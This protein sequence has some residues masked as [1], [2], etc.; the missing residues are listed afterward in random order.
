MGL[1]LLPPL[2]Q[3]SAFLQLLLEEL[4]GLL[5]GIRIV[6][7]TGIEHSGLRQQRQKLALITQSGKMNVLL[8]FILQM[9][10]LGEQ[11]HMLVSVLAPG[12]FLLERNRAD[13]GAGRE[14]IAGMEN[15]RG[16]RLYYS[17]FALNH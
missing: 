10:Q 3:Y 17:D 5:N 4:V 7:H 14:L 13:T 12:D 8:H 1:R 9:N 11:G 2:T 6:W 16:A 15:L